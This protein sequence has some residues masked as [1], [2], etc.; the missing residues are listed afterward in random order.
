MNYHKA[1]WKLNEEVITK[2]DQPRCLSTHNI[3]MKWKT[4]MHV[5]PAVCCNFVLERKATVHKNKPSCERKVPMRQ[6][7]ENANRLNR[8]FNRSEKTRLETALIET[9][10]Q[11]KHPY[12]KE[13]PHRE[14]WVIRNIESITS[15]LFRY[16][17]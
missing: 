10:R 9:E 17:K 12:E 13:K 3:D 14:S 4:F 2:Q 1:D 15:A 8:E 16:R 5:T 6:R 11:L 7:T